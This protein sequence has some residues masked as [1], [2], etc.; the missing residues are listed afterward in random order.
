MKRLPLDDPGEPDSRSAARYLLWVARRQSGTILVGIALGVVWMV[1]Q[2]LVPAALG[3][4]IDAL[5]AHDTARLVAAGGAL[6]GL[7]TVTAISGVMRHR[8]AVTNFLTSG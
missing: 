2:A 7:G 3:A 5:A 1:S 4:G 6:L 8:Y